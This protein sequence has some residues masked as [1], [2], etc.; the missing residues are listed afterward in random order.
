MKGRSR[1]VARSVREAVK[2]APTLV[3]RGLASTYE[4]KRIMWSRSMRWVGDYVVGGSRTRIWRTPMRH[5]NS[6]TSALHGCA[7]LDLAAKAA[8]SYRIALAIARPRS[9]RRIRQ[10]RTA[11]APAAQLHVSGSRV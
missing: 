4:A 5:V 11:L 8:G 1:H 6:A 10:A 9:T 2:L 3:P 7:C